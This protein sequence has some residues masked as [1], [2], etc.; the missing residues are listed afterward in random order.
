M[1][2]YLKGE[3]THKTPTF[4]Y[5]EVAGIGYHVNISL[6]SYSDLEGKT[7]ARVYTHMI[8]KEDSDTI[9]GFSTMDERDLFVLLLSVKGVGGNTARVILS[10]MNPKEVKRAIMHENVGA[11]KSVKG[12]GPKTAKQILLDLKDKVTK[13]SDSD[14]E[15]EIAGETTRNVRDEASAAL[16]ALG[17]QKALV[18]KKIGQVVQSG[19]GELEVEQIIKEVLKQLS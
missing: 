6:N 13:L 19:E 15:L 9:F 18:E 10:Y 14:L 5:L 7:K 8:V 12:I 11:F 4:I 16:Q 17:F 2:G 3:I 1:I